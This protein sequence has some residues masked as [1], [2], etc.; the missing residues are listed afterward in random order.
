MHILVECKDC[1]SLCPKYSYLIGSNYILGAKGILTLLLQD[2][3][4]ML[5][6]GTGE[7]PVVRPPPKNIKNV[8]RPLTMGG[9]STGG[10]KASASVSSR[11]STPSFLKSPMSARRSDEGQMLL[12]RAVEEDDLL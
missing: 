12:S 9:S 1:Y 11:P 3:R 5:G 8:T 6:Q 4:R 10:K 7:S 2:Q